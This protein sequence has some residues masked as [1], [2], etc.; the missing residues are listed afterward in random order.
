[1]RTGTGTG[2]GTEV[3]TLMRTGRSESLWRAGIGM[4]D[5]NGDGI[6]GRIGGR[7]TGNVQKQREILHEREMRLQT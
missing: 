5:A 6:G 7:E 2:T 3:G 4:A 1:M